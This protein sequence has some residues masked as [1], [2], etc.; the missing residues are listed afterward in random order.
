MF[1]ID[2]STSNDLIYAKG[3]GTGFD[4]SQV[5][6][7]TGL[8]KLFGDHP[9]QLKVIPRSEWSARIKEKNELKASLKHLREI[10]ANG[11]KM[12]T[13]DQNGQG[14]CWFYSIARCM[15]YLRVMQNQPY[16]RLSA[17]A[18]ACI[19]KNFRDEGGWSPL[20]AKFVRERGLPSVDFWPEK[21]MSRSND[22]PETWANAAGNI[23]GEDWADLSLPVYDQNLAFGQLATCCLLDIP[24][25]IDLPWW[26]HSVNVHTLVEIGRNDFALDGDNSWTDGWGDDGSFTMREEKVTPMSACALRTINASIN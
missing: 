22:N 4:P 7:D 1:I 26:G 20:A 14:Y 21:S 13:L 6:A 25:T 5:T 24:C 12:P 8:P 11:K 9:S 16:V 23:V 19:V 3:F 2:A 17:H 18:G 10:A 15:Q